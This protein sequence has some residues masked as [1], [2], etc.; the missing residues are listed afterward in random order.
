MRR[1]L[2]GFKKLRNQVVGI[3]IACPQLTLIVALL[4]LCGCQSVTYDVR[5]VPQPIL[6]NQNPCV[7]GKSAF[8]PQ[9]VNIGD[10]YTAKVAQSETVAATSQNT[11]VTIQRAANQAQVNAFNKIG[12]Q[13]NRLIRG[14][15]LDVSFMAV[16][17]LIVLSQNTEIQAHGDIAEVHAA[18]PTNSPVVSP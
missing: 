2:A 8:P 4:G 16:N 9:V 3:G 15:T 17:G 1:F 14:L 5:R 10:D 7:A 18:V 13:P 11:T 12:G 6:L